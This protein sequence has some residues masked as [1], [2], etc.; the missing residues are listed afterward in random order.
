MT[1]NVSPS[2]SCPK[3]IMSNYQKPQHFEGETPLG[4][5][6]WRDIYKTSYRQV[7]AR[8]AL[9]LLNDALLRARRVLS[10]YKVYG[11]SALL[12]PNQTS[13][14]NITALV[15]LSRHY[16]QIPVASTTTKINWNTCFL[17]NAVWTFLLSKLPSRFLN[18]LFT[19]S[20]RLKTV[21]L[22]IFFY[23]LQCKDQIKY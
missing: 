11:D 17:I 18:S 23:F 21:K 4:R 3:E 8:R 16:Q 19:W 15:V 13:L 22:Y 5:K 10:L 20:N 9:S 14:N 7:S 6:I 1:L 2:P 12:L